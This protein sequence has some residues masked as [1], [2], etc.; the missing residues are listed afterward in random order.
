M[1]V[2]RRRSRAHARARDGRGVACQGGGGGGDDNGGAGATFEIWVD[3]KMFYQK[4]SGDVDDGG[5]DVEM[6]PVWESGV[7]VDIRYND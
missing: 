4:V 3:G 2:A 5:Y 7:G 6:T 1:A